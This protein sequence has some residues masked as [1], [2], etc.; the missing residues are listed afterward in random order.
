MKQT[1]DINCDLGEGMPNDS[2]L[3]PYISS[4]NI[5]C[6]AHAGDPEIMRRTIVE[7]I[8]NGVSIGAHPGFADR[9]NFGRKEIECSTNEIY[10]LV[11]AQISELA[12]I[13][14]GQGISLH[15]VKP[16]GALYNIAATTTEIALAIARAV[17]EAD[18]LL[19]L[20]GLSGSEL[21]KAGESLGLKTASEVFADRSYQPDG[22]LTP[23]TMADALIEEEGTAVTRA[24]QMIETATV[25]TTEGSVISILAETICI[26]GDGNNALSLASALFGQLRQRG[27]QLK[28]P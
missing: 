6:G 23:R 22:K 26:H 28:A 5:A 4:A 24:L 10:Q 13:A 12:H 16:H 3:M 2:A 18:P 17:K 8:K 15:H 7:A 19:V 27:I 11:A 25:E 9:E 1:I 21:I 20:Y 14:A